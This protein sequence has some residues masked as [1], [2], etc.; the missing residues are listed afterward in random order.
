MAINCKYEPTPYS[1]LKRGDLVLKVKN[2]GCEVQPISMGVIIEIGEGKIAYMQKDGSISKT[3]NV[4]KLVGELAQTFFHRDRAK[5]TADWTKGDFGKGEIEVPKIDKPEKHEKPEKKKVEKPEK[6]RKPVVIVSPS[7]RGKTFVPK[8][9]KENKEEKEV[10]VVSDEVP[11]IVEKKSNLVAIKNATI[12]QG[13]VAFET[14]ISFKSLIELN[15]YLRDNHELVEDGY[16]KIYV[17]VDFEDGEDWKDRIDVSTTDNNPTWT[18][19]FVAG[20]MLGV[21]FRYILFAKA[22]KD[23]DVENERAKGYAE[24]IS[25]YDMNI[26]SE[27][28]N[29]YVKRSVDERVQ[30]ANWLETQSKRYK[31][32]IKTVPTKEL[33]YKW[34]QEYLGD[35]VSDFNGWGKKKEKVE[36]KKAVEKISETPVSDSPASGV[37]MT[38][39][40]YPS[41][42]PK[43][44]GTMEEVG[45]KVVVIG[46]EDDLD[47]IPYDLPELDGD[48]NETL[49]MDSERDTILDIICA[50]KSKFKK[51]QKVIALSLEELV[52]VTPAK[53]D[54]MPFDEFMKRYNDG[55]SEDEIRAFV[56]Y[57]EAIGE[58]LKG[59]WERYNI[60]GKTAGERQ[61]EM[62]KLINA[63]TLVYDIVLKTYVPSMI[64]YSGN[65][66]QKERDL[67]REKDEFIKLFGQE[68]FENQLNSIGDIKSKFSL[69]LQESDPDKRLIILPISSV[70]LDENFSKILQFKK[71]NGGMFSTDNLPGVDYQGAVLQDC[72]IEWLKSVPASEYLSGSNAYSVT[73]FYIYH[74][75]ITD[76]KKGQAG[77]GT[78]RELDGRGGEKSE[79]EKDLEKEM[80][81]EISQAAKEDGDRLFMQF[82]S[83]SNDYI[84]RTDRIKIENEWNS[85][86]N[87]NVPINPKKIPVAL[88]CSR[89]FKQGKLKLRI[90]QRDGVGFQQKAPSCMLGY[91]TGV[92]KTISAIL[93]AGMKLQSEQVKRPVFIVPNQVYKKWIKEIKGF[94]NEEGVYEHGVLPN[95]KL[96]ELKNLTKQ[97]QKELGLIGKDGRPKQI[98]SGTLSIMTHEAIKQ[99]NFLS[100]N[101]GLKE[102]L[103]EIIDVIE[104]GAVT[105]YKNAIAEFSGMTESNSE[106]EKAQEFAETAKDKLRTLESKYIGFKNDT[107]V[108]FNDFGF[109]AIY[110]DEAH[111]FN[112]VFDKINK[113]ETVD[114]ITKNRRRFRQVSR[115]SLIKANKPSSRALDLFLIAN[116]IQSI[117]KTKESN[118]YLFTATPFTNSPLQIYSVLATI[119]RKALERSGIKQLSDFVETYIELKTILEI[120]TDLSAI[121]VQRPVGFNNLKSLHGLLFDLI[122]YK[123]GDDVALE[124]DSFIR[125]NKH[126]LPKLYYT[127]IRTGLV[128]KLPSDEI[129]ETRLI[130]TN[131]QVAIMEGIE[132]WVNDFDYDLSDVC[133]EVGEKFKKRLAERNVTTEKRTLG[134]R[135]LTGLHIAQA[136]ALTPYMVICGDQ[137]PLSMEDDEMFR[138]SAENLVKTSPKI[139]YTMECIK[140]VKEHHEKNNEEP[141]GQIIYM[142]HHNIVIG[143]N[144]KQSIMPYLK[145]Y[146]T[147]EEFGINYK[148][149][150]VQ[151]ITGGESDDEKEQIK[152]DYNKG[153]VKI[154]IGTNAMSEGMDLQ[155]RSTVLYDL[156]L[157]YNPTTI[158]QLIGRIY[159]Q[160]NMFANV[161]VVFP[162]LEDSSDIFVFQ[163]I[164][165]KTS[166]LNAIFSKNG[167]NV[168]KT[169]EFNADEMKSMLS[170]RPDRRIDLEI[171]METKK[172][173]QTE[174]IKR[175][176]LKNVSQLEID[177]STYKQLL[178]IIKDADIKYDEYRKALSLTEAFKKTEKDYEKKKLSYEER[179][180]KHEEDEKEKV[181]K[182]KKEKKTYLAKPYEPTETEKNLK[183]M[184]Y[185]EWIQHIGVE[186]ICE[187]QSKF[188]PQSE[189]SNKEIVRNVSAFTRDDKTGIDRYEMDRTLRYFQKFMSVYQ[190][191]E[192]AIENFLKPNNMDINSPFDVI[193]EKAKSELTEIIE[194]I[195]EINSPEYREKLLI[196]ETEKYEERRRTQKSVSERV[197]EFKRLNY[198]LDIKKDDERLSKKRFSLERTYLKAVGDDDITIYPDILKERINIFE[199][200]LAEWIA[201]DV[202]EK[203]RKEVLEADEDLAVMISNYKSGKISY[204]TLKKSKFTMTKGKFV[205]H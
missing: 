188:K 199:T 46:S 60:K 200:V 127:S 35:F 196:E 7:G 180:N 17:H 66:Y 190:T 38:S 80:M 172:L 62:D 116:Y 54:L 124:D 76:K 37:E 171:K 75:G 55:I 69:R 134:Q 204:Q 34:I 128:S 32:E 114:L 45:G 40:F 104:Q 113:I 179:R 56:F 181:A 184:D 2:S 150:E 50:H 44:C 186:G 160:G 59:D 153:T 61:I 87:N 63:E 84:D 96:N 125:P 109:D 67:L 117:S 64:Y 39:D 30:D 94:K 175:E 1:K 6:V 25:S 31:R 93:G 132:K 5:A 21:L 99:F 70:C 163:K 108:A 9:N 52:E 185:E 161:R 71:Y 33:F 111:R 157:S 135:I 146:L 43:V 105:E 156:W 103:W 168:I 107:R 202:A 58:P 166:R 78:G 41:N 177:I 11:P 79:A 138:L 143:K 90:A 8:E 130:P 24:L 178:P 194:K 162:I 167:K 136:L 169:E 14:P 48:D 72:F 189:K 183:K 88:T 97:V 192:S 3:K 29:F 106:Y 193:Q 81:D 13:E 170:T 36:R 65:V 140:S 16:D 176:R 158:H 205:A 159:R 112:Q 68:V 4:H 91:D 12:T 139:E 27:T 73:Q 22:L 195:T 174:N 191:V 42:L 18:N 20:Y 77:I 83:S 182:A 100:A 155:T 19:N 201:S 119:N 86:Y 165:T 89:W 126:I 26:E 154:I 57:K 85:R 115:Y 121:Y 131:R 142:E 148:D 118:V 28:F 51:L 203:R 15:N 152:D 133:E 110:V 187:I 53:E 98:E 137:V 129:I 95:I 101:E 74:R 102:K 197:D 49:S 123:T 120:Q 149:H 47:K 122:D 145:R 198:L 82:L 151:F 92:G 23:S 147:D 144:N 164:A 10:V 141:S 173:S